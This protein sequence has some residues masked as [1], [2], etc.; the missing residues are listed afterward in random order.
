MAREL[1]TG[2]GDQTI[3]LASVSAFMRQLA[4]DLHNDL[5]AL[6]LAA[7]YINEIIEEPS[8]KEELGTQ[9]EI[10]HSMSRVL[11]MLSLYLQPPHPGKLTLPAADLVEG[12]RES[13]FKS[14]PAETAA[15]AWDSRVGE[16]QVDADFGM[17]CTALTGVYQN[18]L[19]YRDEGAGIA[20]S[21]VV[22]NGTLHLQFS[23]KKSA[24]PESMDRLGREPFVV[25]KR[26]TYGLGLFYAA[27]VA[28]AHGG[29]LEVRYEEAPGLF[30]VEIVLPV[31]AKE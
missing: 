6:D 19:R 28:R 3:S 5:N 9:R 8:A 2:E 20:F 10:I 26:R 7:T 4:H 29:G 15:L 16:S 11:H 25:V 1:Q 23:E 22:K 27:Q 17:I 14:H 30:I 13:L 18:A 12:F 24:A 31:K 21:A